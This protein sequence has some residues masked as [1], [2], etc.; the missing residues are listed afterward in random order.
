MR[1][2]NNFYHFQ[3]YQSKV[4]KTL[5]SLY[6]IYMIGLWSTPRIYFSN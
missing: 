6:H 3:S 4:G 1:L 5:S 2:T